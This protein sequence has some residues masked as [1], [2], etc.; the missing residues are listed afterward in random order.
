MF[1]LLGYSMYWE[2][3]IM[4]IILVPGILF[5]IYAQIKVSSTV[6]AYSKVPA[7]SGKTG[8]EVARMLLDLAGLQHIQIKRVAGN[9]TDY[10]DHKNKTLAL[11][12]SVHD[13]TSVTALGVATHE[14]G[15]ALQYKSGYAPIKLRNLAIP[16]ANFASTLMWPLLIIG[17]IFNFAIASNG[18]FGDIMLWGGIAVFGLAVIVNLVTLP[19]EYN[20]SN[21]ALKILKQSN[22]L[23]GQ[24]NIYAKKVL[25]AA[26]LTYVAALLVSILNLIRFLIVIGNDR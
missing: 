22:L 10:Y 12:A 19:V 20:A 16:L 7:S 25:N 23:N 8:A 13:S 24:E 15:H 6:S 9:L 1:N 11:S 17:M 26:A 21:R 5:S 14:V 2:Y 18:I 3:Y 4:G